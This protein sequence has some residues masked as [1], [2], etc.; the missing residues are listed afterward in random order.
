MSSSLYRLPEKRA[1][2]TVQLEDS[3]V[4]SHYGECDVSIRTL[5]IIRGNNS[6]HICT[7]NE[8]CVMEQI[9]VMI[10][11]NMMQ[12]Y[13]KYVAIR[14]SAVYIPAGLFSTTVTE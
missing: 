6:Q 8:C 3:D 4:S 2:L 11:R 1:L 12:T 13:L 14:W 9:Q 10:G 5:I 7:C